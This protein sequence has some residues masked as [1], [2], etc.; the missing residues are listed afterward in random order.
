MGV[1]FGSKMNSGVSVG[2]A[3]VGIGACVGV[4]CKVLP[5][6]RRVGGMVGGAKVGRATVG[7]AKITV[8]AEGVVTSIGRTT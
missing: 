7:T 5:G 1:P 2:G 8:A 4:A 3:R 6:R